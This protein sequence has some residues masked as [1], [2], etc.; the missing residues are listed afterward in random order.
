[1]SP[2]IAATLDFSLHPVEIADRVWWVGHVQDDAFQCHTYL[3]E[4]G[5]Q[6]VLIDP[7]SLLTFRHTLAK[8]EQII[9]FED[10]RYFVCQHPDPDITSALPAIDARLDRPDAMIVT[11]WR[12][13]ALIRHYNLRLPF[14][15]VDEHDWQ[16]ALA[17][18]QLRFIFT[19]YAHYPGA[20]C[21]FD[22]RTA[23][24]FSSDLFGGM[25]K[26]FALVAED[27]DYFEAMRPFHEHYM[28][29]RDIL[30]YA[31]ARIEEHPVRLIAPQHG[32]I[33][34]QAL[35]RPILDRLRH[36]ECGLYLQAQQFED[37]RLI[38]QANRALHDMLETVLSTTRFPTLAERVLNILKC[39]LPL[40]TLEFYAQTPAGQSL[41]LGPGNQYCGVLIDP[42]AFAADALGVRREP[43]LQMYGCCCRAVFPGGSDETVVLLL[44]LFSP[45]TEIASALALFRLDSSAEPAGRFCSLL[46]RMA[47]PL[48]VAL[49]W[50]VIHW[51]L[52]Q[53]RQQLYERA[54]RDPLTG[55][56]TRY[57]MQETLQ[58]LLHLHDRD[59]AACIGL[60]LIDI[61]YFKAI[62]DNFGHPQGDEVL[63]QVGQVLLDSVR[64]G[65][66]PV[67][68][69]GDEFAIFALG[70]GEDGVNCLAER[71][72]HRF[73]TLE[74]MPPL[75]QWQLTASIG[76]A[77]RHQQESLLDFIRRADEA[78]YAAKA[79]GRNRV[80]AAGEVAAP[81]V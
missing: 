10:V 37:I 11:H 57:Y 35:I 20:F 72:R 29:S 45:V 15:L 75:A 4:Q 8:I 18:R 62:N 5:R 61:D 70:Q 78:L 12:S 55:L 66:L 3:I 13:R 67:R 52:D 46:E 23:V 44:P 19:P 48:Q 63:R 59:A 68:L 79:A 71:I 50:E 36:L 69:G 17:D 9:P 73:A 14:W 41:Y 26:R 28:P 51:S 24:L 7:G 22:T 31:L 32:S 49:E 65:D 6:S 81:G 30:G 74:L 56:Y 77:V 2:P 40:T 43:W 38:V 64:N 54:M 33:I 47:L 16:L 58:R 34:P 1:M 42:P 53:E 27:E 80:V 39:L 25:T 76:T 21:S 60:M